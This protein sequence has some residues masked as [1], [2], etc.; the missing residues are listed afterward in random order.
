MNITKEEF[1]S[2]GELVELIAEKIGD[3]NRAIHSETA[4]SASALLSGSLLLR[5]FNLNLNVGEPGSVLLSEEANEQGP[6]LVNILGGFL[7]VFN[8]H[9]NNEKKAAMKVNEAIHL[10]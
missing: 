6:M 7:Q 10:A 9:I 2:A 3:S 4:I 5:S 8:I 1:D